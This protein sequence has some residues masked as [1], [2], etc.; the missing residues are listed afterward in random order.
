LEC[1]GA[2]SDVEN[3]L[4]FAKQNT[5][6]HHQTK[7]SAARKAGA[8]I[9]NLTVKKARTMWGMR[10]S[11]S[12]FRRLF[13]SGR[14]IATAGMIAAFV[15]APVHVQAAATETD[16]EERVRD[17]ILSHPEVILEALE[18]LSRREMLAAM[19]IRI[20]RHSDLFSEPAVLGIGPE[21]GPITVVEFF[22]YRCVPCKAMHPKLK[23]ALEAHPDVRVE[24]RH[25]PILSPGSER[26][27]RFALAVKNIAAADVY[28]AVHQD[29]WELNG[30]LRG[31]VFQ[32]I[33]QT[34]G[35]DWQAIQKEMDSAAVSDR[36]SRNR[37]IAI[38]LEVLGT[39][40]FVTPTSVSFGQVDAGQLVEGWLSQ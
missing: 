1:F 17:Y 24:M 36:I 10:S 14:R 15:A 20:A 27:A 16:F 33:A 30:P 23:T 9:Q 13:L 11:K 35:L 39:P 21:E 34:H 28:R 26:G 3:L 5:V 29:I 2:V 32:K 6:D 4:W 40:A 25:L 7:Q 31:H 12:S 37:D 8:L 18:I 22:D 38:D 19:S